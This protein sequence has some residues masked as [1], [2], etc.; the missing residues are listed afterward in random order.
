MNR[1]DDFKDAQTRKTCRGGP[2]VQKILRGHG[3]FAIKR[4]SLGSY[5]LRRKSYIS[6]EGWAGI[7]VD[8]DSNPDKLAALMIPSFL[9][10]FGK[11]NRYGSIHAVPVPPGSRRNAYKPHVMDIVSPD[12]AHQLGVE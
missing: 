7:V 1:C 5:A 3:P 4:V 8:K 11:K 9:D 2:A 12:V 10:Y 6:P